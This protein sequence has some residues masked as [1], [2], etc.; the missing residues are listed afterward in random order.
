MAPIAT[1]LKQ[2]HELVFPS[3]ES[4]NFFAHCRIPGAVPL[5]KHFAEK[6]TRFGDTTAVPLQPPPPTSH[7]TPGSAV[8]DRHAALTP[9]WGTAKAFLDLIA[10]QAAIRLLAWLCTPQAGSRRNEK[11]RSSGKDGGLSLP[12]G[13]A[14]CQR[15]RSQGG[16]V[17]RICV[18]RGGEGKESTRFLEVK[19]N[20]PSLQSPRPAGKTEAWFNFLFK[21][22]PLQV[23]EMSRKKKNSPW[24]LP[25]N[26]N[27]KPWVLC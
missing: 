12:H 20:W 18:L 7:K 1:S 3:D 23:A 19:K 17:P 5:R 15:E 8:S 21:E 27:L 6:I 4:Q 10:R 13:H 2:L 11:G 22:N 16:A 14:E 24:N 9:S 25:P 26:T